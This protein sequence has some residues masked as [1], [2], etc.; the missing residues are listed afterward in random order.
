[1]SD[2][3]KKEY[4]A[5]VEAALKANAEAAAK[6][7]AAQNAEQEKWNSAVAEFRQ[8]V[9]FCDAALRPINE[10]ISKMNAEVARTK[11]NIIGGM[12]DSANFEVKKAN[13]T[14]SLLFTIS[15]PHAEISIAAAHAKQQMRF[16]LP[17]TLSK[18]A[19][20]GNSMLNVLKKFID[21]AL[22]LKS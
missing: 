7:R 21:E 19:D 14:Q 18:G 2:D 1:M 9:S 10:G 8:A 22:G 6:Q 20:L 13:V 17:K 12:H 11:T 15:P 4:E 3:L 5:K 16:D